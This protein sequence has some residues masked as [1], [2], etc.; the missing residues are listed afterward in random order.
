MAF[1]KLTLIATATLG[2]LASLGVHA[3]TAAAPSSV[4]IWG[5][6]DAYAGRQQLS[7]REATTVVG[8]G[9]LTTSRVAFMGSEDLGGGLR[10]NFN[11]QMFLRPDSGELGRFPGDAAFAGRSTVGLSGNF[12]EFNMGRMN[13]PLFF[14]LLRQDVFGLAALGP[15]FQHIFPGGQ[16]IVAPQSVTDSTINNGL[17][18][19]TPN[20]AG[21]RAAVHYG[22]SETSPHK[23]RSGYSLSYINKGLDVAIAGDHIK[24]GPLAVGES[25]QTSQLISVAY[26]F[27]SFKLVGIAQRQKQEVLR[28]TYKIYNLGA[29]I[30]VMGA[31]K[32]LVSYS[33]TDL[34]AV[35]GDRTRKTLAVSYNHYL[36]KRTDLYVLA[37]SDKVS[38]LDRGTTLVGGIRHRF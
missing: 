31:H 18:Y 7:G 27:G 10:A 8:S 16:P 26:D 3:Q 38:N 5:I 28:N 29:S 14:T 35:L 21:F 6:V 2:V 1:R 34:D 24:A 15:M 37:S 12:G 17:Q 32:V 13:S 9:G 25:K 36:S 11:L 4:T 20:L 19:A 30:P 23:G 33:H 22:M